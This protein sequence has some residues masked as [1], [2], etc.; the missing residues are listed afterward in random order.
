MALLFVLSIR[1]ITLLPFLLLLRSSNGL[2]YRT[3]KT[4]LAWSSRVN[5]L[6]IV[7]C[8][9]GWGTSLSSSSSLSLSSAAN[10]TTNALYRNMKLLLPFRIASLLLCIDMLLVVVLRF[11]FVSFSLFLSQSWCRLRRCS[12]S[13]WWS[14]FPP[15]MHQSRLDRC[16]SLLLS[17]TNH[18]DE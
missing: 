7:R 10:V 2:M 6:L 13:G 17:K 5:L 16:F 12:G 14:W 11:F 3:E 15:F 9:F 1:S 8:L 4:L 18:N